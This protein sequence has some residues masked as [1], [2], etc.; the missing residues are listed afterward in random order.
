MESLVVAITRMDQFQFTEIA[1]M[2]KHAFPGI[3][4][5]LSALEILNIIEDQLKKV[6]DGQKYENF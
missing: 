2:L 4:L 6:E 1:K 5:V 3:D